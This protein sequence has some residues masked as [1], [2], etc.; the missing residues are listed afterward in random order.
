MERSPISGLSLAARTKQ[1]SLSVHEQDGAAVGAHVSAHLAHHALHHLAHVQRA[2][3]GLGDL[4]QALE[5]A[6][7]ERVV[8][9]HVPLGTRRG[10]M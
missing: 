1:R 4:E 10:R 7:A 9:G 5:L 8:A 2:G 3:D 6:R